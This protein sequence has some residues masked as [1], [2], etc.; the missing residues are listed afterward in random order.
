MK[1]ILELGLLSSLAF[2]ACTNQIK[3]NFDDRNSQ[4]Y[5]CAILEAGISFN[6]MN[7]IGSNS[8]FNQNLNFLDKLEP[9]RD[10]N[11]YKVIQ[12][13]K[14][15][16]LYGYSMRTHQLKELI[17]VN[18]ENNR[19]LYT[20]KLNSNLDKNRECYWTYHLNGTTL[21]SI[22]TC[23]KTKN[24]RYF[25]YIPKWKSYGIRKHLIYQN[26][27]LV[28]TFLHDEAYSS[29]KM[30]DENGTFIEEGKTMGESDF[31][32]PFQSYSIE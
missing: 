22:E 15:I 3:P 25:D 16:F 23:D 8:N 2:T 9:K 18:A 4:Y 11:Y 28:T 32:I 17:T 14:K 5:Y 29:I 20:K 26:N 30:Y 27:K 12:K 19:L 31:C 24:V 21:K 1:R 13:D 10:A 6:I 7:K